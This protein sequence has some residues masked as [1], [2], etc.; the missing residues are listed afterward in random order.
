MTEKIPSVN[1]FLKEDSEKLNDKKESSVK[2]DPVAME[3]LEKLNSEIS[4]RGTETAEMIRNAQAKKEL[5]DESWDAKPTTTYEAPINRKP[6]G[7]LR[8]WAIGIFGGILSLGA[9]KEAKAG[10]DPVDSLNKKTKIE[11]ISSNTIDVKEG[12]KIREITAQERKDWNDF[13]DF[14]ESKGLKGSEKLDKGN[15][16]LARGLFQEYKGLHPET[17]LSYE[18]VPSVQYEMQKLRQSIQGFAE[19]RNDPNAK[20]L[21]NFVSKVDGWFGSHTSQSKFPFMMENTFHNDNLMKSENL[22]LVNSNLETEK[23]IKKKKSLPPGVTLE[24]L[25][26][27]TFYTDPQSGDLVRYE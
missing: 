25:E 7:G 17:T 21:M 27:G 18:I 26:G 5:G 24:K 22:G 9:T 2:V 14:V 8:K 6:I 11:K 4:F 10:G 1:E 20:N 16:A 13:V 12:L 19:R 3:D 23:Q 15:D